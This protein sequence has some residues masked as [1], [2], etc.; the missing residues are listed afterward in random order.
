MR[1]KMHAVYDHFPERNPIPGQPFIN[2]YADSRVV[3]CIAPDRNIA[4]LLEPRSMIKEYYDYVEQH[5]N[6][7]NYIF[8]HDS[9]LLTFPNARFLNWGDVWH[10]SD[11]VKDKGISLIASWKNWCPLHEARIELAKFYE[12]NSKVDVYGSYR[13]RETWTSTQEAH[14]HYKFAIV[15]ENDIDEYWFTEKL[16]N[17]LSNKVVP[18]YVGATR[19]GDI[20]NAEGIIQVHN[21]KLIPEIVRT[22][23]IDS[24]YQKRQQA[25]DDNYI[26]VKAYAKNWK[27]RFFE[28]YESILEGLLNE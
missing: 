15:I 19:I 6:Y 21:W 10:T 13:D 26:R 23:D 18:I 27:D 7:F 2:C 22:L 12:N 24:E 28:D 9:R 1:I 14:E 8:T 16:L 25:I 4:M 17:C 20:F 5:Y 3:E 11:S